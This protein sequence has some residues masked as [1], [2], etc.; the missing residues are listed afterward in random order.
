MEYKLNDVLSDG[1]PSFMSEFEWEF[2]NKSGERKRFKLFNHDKSIIVGS[3]IG[4]ASSLFVT[5]IGNLLLHPRPM[6]NLD[7]QTLTIGIMIYGGA[8][9][10]VKLIDRMEELHRLQSKDWKKAMEEMMEEVC[11]EH[12]KKT[13]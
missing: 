1:K 6:T 11:E 3:L 4:I 2:Y 13:R 7:I 8:I 9:I 5:S 10:T 12:D